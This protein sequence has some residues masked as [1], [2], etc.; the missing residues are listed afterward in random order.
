MA[1]DRAERLA[2]IV[3]AALEK[4]TTDCRSF[5]EGACAG[6]QALRAEV[7]SL[8][9]GR[10]EATE[11]I[12]E[13]A[14]HRHAD[15]LENEGGEILAGQLLGN[16]RIVSLLGRGGMGEVYLA[17]DTA[18]GRQ[19]AIKLVSRFGGLHLRRHFRQEERILA[20]LTHPHIARLYGSAVTEHGLPYFV[21]EYV[22]GERLDRYCEL[23]QPDIRARL[24][25]F[26]KLCAAVEYAH[27]RL[28]IHRDLKPA[29]IRVSPEGEPKLLDFGIAK[30]LNDEATEAGQQT[31]T[32]LGVMTPEYASPEQA[33]GE[34][35]TTASDVYSLGVI[36]Y[37][38]LSG[39]KPY[40]VTSRRPEEIARAITEQEP[41]RPSLALLHDSRFTVHDSRVLKGDLDNVVMMALRKEPER[42][43][44]SVASLA[45]DIRRHLEGLPVMARNDTL[46]YRA[47]KFIQRH[48]WSVAA[49]A[50]IV[51]TLLGGIAG[52]SWEAHRA[53]QQRARAE[54]R[55]AQ[56]RQLANSLVFELN[57][58][59]ENLPGS[60]T[61]RALLVRRASEYLDS[62]ATEAADDPSLQRELS[63]A[64][65][66][67][68]N[69][70]G[71]P[72]TANLGDRTGALRS[73][74]R[75]RK[76]AEQLLSADAKDGKALRQLAVTLEKI[77]EVQAAKG[78]L[79]AAV[80]S[81]NRSLALFKTLAQAAPSN[82]NVRVSLAISHQK[83]GDVL[84]N[85]DFPNA[86]DRAGA[87]QNYR[88]SL[89]ILRAVQQ[90][91]P[92]NISANRL[93]GVAHER[94]GT[95]LEAEGD[96]AAAR[97]SFR[98]SQRL[99]EQLARA[100]P[101]DTNIIRDVAIAHEKMANVLTQAG[102]FQRAL[103][104]RRRSLATFQ[105]LAEADPQN[106]QAQQS[107]AISHFHLADLLGKP[108]SPNL[109]SPAEALAH[110]RK[111]AAIL[112]QV[113][114]EGPLDRQLQ[115]ILN[116]IRDRIRTDSEARTQAE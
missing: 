72:N 36:L 92:E 39:Q 98:E 33:R 111:A 78:A 24:E 60:T 94:L 55:F 11:F 9:R 81:A 49:A 29:N 105:R 35:M 23:H 71:N 51:L 1:P 67:I 104:N 107:L 84:G 52:T 113:E 115:E 22:P 32:V 83:L 6:D 17:E 65:V 54:R 66:K 79:P 34:Q 75:A 12:E 7:E 68:G 100:H 102:E 59:I 20:G 5:I 82:T 43:Y 86:G 97:E 106:V 18:L 45:E 99:R 62:L 88:A 61:A 19:V 114:K 10:D 108:G 13:P 90:N 56:V 93:L 48:K 57:G 30:L 76:I 21:M 15:L 85:P 31:I 28:V 58:A 47:G 96:I 73:Y 25:M 3:E 4:E 77:G 112:V 91:E 46:G 14:F 53:G 110:Y 41:E 109:G 2:E 69:V 42:R 89:A 101:N 16:Y 37:Q 8:L 64:Y 103:A 80:L 116:T 87:L 40:R 50:I 70:Q 44:A 27:Q 26:R 63:A 95:V 38:L 74:E